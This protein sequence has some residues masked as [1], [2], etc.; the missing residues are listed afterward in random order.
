MQIAKLKSKSF[1]LMT[2]TCRAS[3]TPGGGDGWSLTPYFHMGLTRLQ[4]AS[5]P[6]C[7]DGFKTPLGY[8][9]EK[10]HWEKNIDADDCLC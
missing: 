9:K 2:Y 4:A 8:R 10:K 7:Y 1:S 6:P 5:C 3:H